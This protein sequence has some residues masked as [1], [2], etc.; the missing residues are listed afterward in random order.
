[1]DL[2]R[3]EQQS[4]FLSTALLRPVLEPPCVG[5]FN[6]RLLL[7]R[8]PAPRE[9]LVITPS[10]S[11]TSN[12]SIE[13]YCTKESKAMDF[14]TARRPC[15]VHALQSGETGVLGTKRK[16]MSNVTINYG[17]EVAGRDYQRTTERW[18]CPRASS[19]FLCKLGAPGEQ[20]P[21]GSCQQPLTPLTGLKCLLPWKLRPSPGC[22]PFRVV[23]E[24]H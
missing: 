9:N 22:S 16:I 19:I 15:G 10:T 12:D 2:L 18:I 14:K 1:M 3:K 6:A 13:A 23:P 20:G 21:H 17:A 7:S 24:M 8:N 5:S 11:R 4:T